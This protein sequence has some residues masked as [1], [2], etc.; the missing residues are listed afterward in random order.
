MTKFI[1]GKEMADEEIMAIINRCMRNVM[2]DEYIAK[3]EARAAKR[4]A[5]RQADFEE[6]IKF[7]ERVKTI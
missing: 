5:Q 2:D 3:K 6:C 7:C 1:N 4:A